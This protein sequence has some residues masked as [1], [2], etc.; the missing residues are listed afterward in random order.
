MTILSASRNRGQPRIRQRLD[1][2]V[3][4]RF[5]HHCDRDLIQALEEAP[6]KNALIR[7]ALRLWVR[8]NK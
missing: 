8:E 2:R 3:T 1:L 5:R 4:I 7:E 6:N